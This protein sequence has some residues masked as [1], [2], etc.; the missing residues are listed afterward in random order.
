MD[1]ML[2]SNPSKMKYRSI[3]TVLNQ[4]H[5]VSILDRRRK[6]IC[7]KQG[8][9]RK[10]NVN[11]ETLKDMVINELGTSSSIQGYRQMTEILAIRYGV[12]TSEEDVRKTLKNIDPEEVSIRRNKVIRRTMYHT[13][14]PGYIYYIDGNDKQKRW[15]FPIH[16]C[17]G[18]FSRKVIWLVVSTT[19][20]D[21]LLVGNLCL[22]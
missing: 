14:G 8:R 19:N 13:I 4:H 9:S 6:Y 2:A 17:I 12:S 20:N 3:C 18:G 1:G 21:A 15:G 11:N 10:R 5:G 22:N 7:K 16:G